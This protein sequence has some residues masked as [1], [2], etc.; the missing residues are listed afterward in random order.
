[1]DM[2][3]SRT[4]GRATLGELQ[5]VGGKSPRLKDAIVARQMADYVSDG[6]LAGKRDLNNQLVAELEHVRNYWAKCDASTATGARLD[7]ILRYAQFV[8]P[9][10]PPEDLTGVWAQF[11]DSRCYAALSP[12]N[13]YW[14]T[15][16]A[17]VGRRDAEGMESAARTVLPMHMNSP[18]PAWG[19]DA[20]AG[21]P[22]E[23][24]YLHVALVTALL[25]QGKREEAKLAWQM[26]LAVKSERFKRTPMAL[27][28][29]ATVNG[30]VSSK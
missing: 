25:A 12:Y 2:L 5:V 3:Q 17:A 14:L 23:I 16:F 28:L 6:S 21:Y 22:H 19:T 9:G 7:P 26:V 8:N 4:P 30:K 10:L 29:D 20:T 24:E 18:V 1:M 27:L 15:L 11:T 13:R